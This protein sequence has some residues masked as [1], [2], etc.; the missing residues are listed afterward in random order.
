M[1]CGISFGL[2]RGLAEQLTPCRHGLAVVGQDDDSTLERCEAAQVACGICDLLQNAV[3][4]GAVANPDGAKRVG[5]KG[6]IGCWGARRGAA[7][8][9]TPVAKWQAGPASGQAGQRVIWGSFDLQQQDQAMQHA[10]VVLGCKDSGP[11]H[12][13]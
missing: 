5:P 4:E 1:E 8:A 6:E 3:A 13:K 12:C 7:E 10:A 9:E 11:F 2:G